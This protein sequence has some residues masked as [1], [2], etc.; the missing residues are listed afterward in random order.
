MQN[1]TYEG[2]NREYYEKQA[3]I[4]ENYIDKAPKWRGGITYRGLDLT[5]M[6]MDSIKVG[7]NFK[8][9]GTSSWTTDYKIAEVFSSKKAIF[10]S[11]TQEKG[12]S[13]KFGSA[14]SDENEIVVSKNANY[15]VRR[16]ERLPNGTRLFYVDEV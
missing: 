16:I 10:V 8:M 1:G 6:Q 11:K 3:K 15:K 5:T 4:L 7:E 9:G 13:I 12:T 14:F 2:N